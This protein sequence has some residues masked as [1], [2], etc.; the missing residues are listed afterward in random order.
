MPPEELDL[1]HMRRALQ[2][3][4]QGR[5]CVEPNPLVGCV[6]ARGTQVL[7]EGW[8]QQFGGP[9]AEI[10]ALAAAGDA[11]GATL[12]VTLEPC[13]HYGKTPPCS[14]AVIRAGIARV[15]VAQ[16][17]PFPQVAGKGLA[18][19]RQAGLEITA[20]VLQDEARR[21]NAPYLKLVQR[22]RPWIVA[23]W[24]MTLDG[25][26][27]TRTGH[28]RWISS[29][30]SR[31]LVHQLRGGVDAIMVG[32]G[33]AT[34]DDPQLTARPPGPRRAVR[35]VVDSAARLALD[36]RL[37]RSLDQ[38]PVLVA[39]GTQADPQRCRSLHQAGCEVLACAGADHRQRLHALLD[40]LGRR[41]WTN[42]LVEGGAGLL[43][44]LFDLGEVDE[45]H[46]FIAPM[47]V[48]GRA[49]RT[50]IAGQGVERI[51]QALQLQDV[52][53]QQLG[54]DVHVHGL[55]GRERTE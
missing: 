38:T 51:Q 49:S 3:A 50:P 44:N 14:Q 27:A 21:L 11:R 1:C 13:C 12:Y 33:T 22:Q 46:A 24:A 37:V 9:H 34:T 28:S 35:I 4:A 32:S 47:L 42:V 48:G 10:M 25:K 53:V 5:G 40:E 39:V 6:I 8:H 31:Q 15:V 54:T 52:T 55:V 7:G 16:Q 45:V 17:D 29:E 36:S 18:A 30:P 26:L 43:G 41:R 23:K 20:G 2:L 19:L